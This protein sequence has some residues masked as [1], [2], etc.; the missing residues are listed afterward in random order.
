VLARIAAH[1]GDDTLAARARDIL[2]ALAPVWTPAAPDAGLYVRA[3]ME[4]GR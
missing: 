2:G 3:V 4:V 1:V